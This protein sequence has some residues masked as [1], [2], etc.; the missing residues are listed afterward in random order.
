LHFRLL[1][2]FAKPLPS[3]HLKTRRALNRLL[4]NKFMMLGDKQKTKGGGLIAG[5]QKANI[6]PMTKI[7]M[8]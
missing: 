4:L 1:F 3:L 6:Y 8:N 7:L 2:Y 5:F